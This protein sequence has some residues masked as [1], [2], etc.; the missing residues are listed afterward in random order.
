[1]TAYLGSP[2]KYTDLD[3]V[4]L[5]FAI[6]KREKWLLEPRLQVLGQRG[7]RVGS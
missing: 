4:P 2:N 1:M 5:S 3:T 7:W 6:G